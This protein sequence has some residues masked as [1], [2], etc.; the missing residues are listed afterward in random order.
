VLLLLALY[1]GIPLA[2]EAHRIPAEVLSEAKSP[3]P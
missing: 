3:A 2:N 1:C